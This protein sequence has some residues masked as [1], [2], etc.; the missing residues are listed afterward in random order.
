MASKIGSVLLL[1]I[2]IVLISH[3]SLFS[4]EALG[5]IKKAENFS[6]KDVNGKVHSLS[7]YKNSKAIVLMFIATQCPVSNAYNGRMVK[8]YN[9]YSKKN[10]AIIGINSNKQE[11]IEEIKNHS[12]QNGFKFPV[13]KD[14][15]NVIAD[16]FQAG[17]TPEIFV[18]NSNYEILYHGRID[19]SRDESDVESRDL[20]ISLNEI[21]SGKPVSNP[22]TKAFGCTIK[23]VSG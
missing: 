9:E 4:N 5:K 8:L 10:I 6:L 7:D 21:L 16:K 20:A 3:A 23:R 22:E 19:D 15:N 11:G 1:L 14:V 17:H 18:L 13:L 2:A 12:A